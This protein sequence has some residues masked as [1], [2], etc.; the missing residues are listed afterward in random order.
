MTDI[1]GAILCASTVAIVVM[2]SEAIAPVN[3]PS[4]WA[5]RAALS[6]AIAV[7]GIAAIYLGFALS[8]EIGMAWRPYGKIVS[9]IGALGFA[10]CTRK[11][12]RW[13]PPR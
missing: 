9:G 4:M 3:D 11:A 7:G 10:Y 5:R 6:F 1:G 12:M 13:T 8:V 2:I